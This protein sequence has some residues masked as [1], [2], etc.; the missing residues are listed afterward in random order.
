MHVAREF[1]M[2]DKTSV[3]FVWVTLLNFVITIAEIIGGVLSGSLALLSDALHN[4]GDTGAIFLSFIAHLISKKRKNKVK[5]FGYERAE[6]LAAFTNGIVLIVICFFLMVEACIRF[7]KPEPIKGNLMLIVAII[8][9]AANVISMVTM[10]SDSK[11][12][13]NVKSTF[14]HMFS[15]ALSSVVVVIG[16]LIIKRWQIDWLDPVL[17]II[18]SLFIL[19]EAIKITVKAANILMESNPSIDLENLKEV[20]LNNSEIKHIHHV[21]VWKY[22][23]SLTMLDAHINVPTDFKISDLEHLYIK[24][25]EQ[26]APL[27]INHVILQPECQRGLKEQMIANDEND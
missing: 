3:K 6:T 2:K 18:V 23:D 5:T 20:L 16:A 4:L 9:L 21:H 14:V 10:H 8:G 26:V 24:V 1:S 15:D 7:A 25:G 11:K 12:N 13:L 17:T 22:S 27:G 19:Y